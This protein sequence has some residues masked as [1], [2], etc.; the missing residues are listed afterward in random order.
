MGPRDHLGAH[1]LDDRRMGVAGQ[2][3]SVSA[4]EVDVLSAVDVVDLG[5]GPVTQPDRLGRVICQLEVTPPAK[6]GAP[7]R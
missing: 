2:A 3:R 7:L 4:V 5:P 1:G 6:P